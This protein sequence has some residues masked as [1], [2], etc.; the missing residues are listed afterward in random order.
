MNDA[1]CNLND[2]DRI[3]GET[4]SL[5]GTK[6]VTPMPSRHPMNG[7][8]PRERATPRRHAVEDRQSGGRVR[9]PRGD[10]AAWSAAAARRKTPRET[11]AARDQDAPALRLLLTWDKPSPCQHRRAEPTAT[12]AAGNSPVPRWRRRQPTTPMSTPPDRSGGNAPRF[13]GGADV[14]VFRGPARGWIRADGGVVTA[15]D[16]RSTLCN[17]VQGCSGRQPMMIRIVRAPKG[18]PSVT[19]TCDRRPPIGPIHEPE[20]I[21]GG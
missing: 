10:E 12:R 3:R 13:D 21:S 16:P 20:L 11:R 18:R 9:T 5:E 4:G 17:K 1:A 8:M 7:T 2:A 19:E 14:A 6:T 15:S